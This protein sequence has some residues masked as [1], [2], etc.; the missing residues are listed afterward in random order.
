MN[1][2]DFDFYQEYLAM[3]NPPKIITQA[4]LDQNMEKHRA[5]YRGKLREQGRHL[6]SCPHKDYNQ[7]RVAVAMAECKSKSEWQVDDVKYAQISTTGVMIHKSAEECLELTLDK[8]QQKY[9]IEDWYAKQIG[10]CERRIAE[11]KSEITELTGTNRKRALRGAKSKLTHWQARLTGLQCNLMASWNK[12]NKYEKQSMKWTGIIGHIKI[13]EI[14][15]TIKDERRG[16][17]NKYGFNPKAQSRETA[18]IM[19][20]D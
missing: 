8:V 14:A 16:I 3:V 19:F 18:E 9:R 6:S 7:T 10:D 15:K 11:L 17:G 12:T 20:N 1:Q 4:E 13:A 2:K 5:A